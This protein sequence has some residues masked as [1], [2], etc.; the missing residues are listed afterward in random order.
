MRKFLLILLAVLL[1]CL[2][3]AA[4]EDGGDILGKEFPNF[5]VKDTDGN[6]F[7]LSKALKDHEAVLINI[8]ATWCSPCMRDFPSLTEAYEQY[9]DRVAFIALSCEEKDTLELIG[10]Y[11]KQNGITFPMGRDKNLTLSN[12]IPARW[13]P[14][15]VI[16]DR[17]GNAAFLYYGIFSDA[18]QIS[19]VLDSFL[20]D[21]YTETRVLNEIPD[22]KTQP[23]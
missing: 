10:E 5:T 20:G 7:S 11:R 2:G 12:Y 23:E 17:F 15:T 16:V 19:R 22:E 14:C 1:L 8:W 18:R 13:I 9:K 21:G 4:A 3:T 6:F